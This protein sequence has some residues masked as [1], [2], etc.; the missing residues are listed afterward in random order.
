MEAP[1]MPRP[2]VISS[3]F[4]SDGKAP[5]EPPSLVFPDP[6]KL[7]TAILSSEY[8]KVYCLVATK[9]TPPSLELAKGQF[10]CGQG[11]FLPS[12]MHLRQFLKEYEANSHYG[13]VSMKA[14]VGDATVCREDSASRETVC[15][16]SRRTV[17]HSV[18]RRESRRIASPSS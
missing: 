12:F 17:Q 15:T 5:D 4:F 2:L 7:F 11:A 8:M 1:G 14:P 18:P 13:L 10:F 16:F 3:N 9:E 6:F